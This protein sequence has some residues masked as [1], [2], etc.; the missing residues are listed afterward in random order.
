MAA[1]LQFIENPTIVVV[2]P[3][4]RGG[5]YQI[6]F[7]PRTESPACGHR[8]PQALL[9]LIFLEAGA[10]TDREVADVI[11]SVCEPARFAR[12]RAWAEAL[13]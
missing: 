8:S 3:P 5:R 10:E 12:A 4:E 2:P 6:E 1:E 9:W 11:C 7:R 13:R